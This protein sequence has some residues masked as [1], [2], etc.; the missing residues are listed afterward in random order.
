MGWGRVSG[1]EQGSRDSVK[2]YLLPCHL[3]LKSLKY[4]GDSETDLGKHGWACVCFTSQSQSRELQCEQRAK[5]KHTE[6]T[7]LI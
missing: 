4:D 7:A 1:G 2:V 3:R 5:A 6:R